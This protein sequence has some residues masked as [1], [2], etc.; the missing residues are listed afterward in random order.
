M[1]FIISTIINLIN[2]V[3]TWT[4]CNVLYMFVDKLD[5]YLVFDTL[6]Y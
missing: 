3:T 6:N 2:W 5:P 1:I 4:Y